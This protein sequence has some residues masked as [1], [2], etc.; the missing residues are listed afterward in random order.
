VHPPQEVVGRLWLCGLPET[1]DMDA[2][3]M[4]P[5]E[6]V[7]DGPVLATGVELLKAP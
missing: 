1:A 3:G 2:L 7:A 4:D 5:S 6:H